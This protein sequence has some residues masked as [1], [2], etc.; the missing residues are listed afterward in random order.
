M[1]KLADGQMLDNASYGT[2]LLHHGINI[3]QDYKR[4]R[5]I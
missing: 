3:K 2:G 1:T 4:H 5:A